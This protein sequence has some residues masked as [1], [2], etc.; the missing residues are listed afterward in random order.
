MRKFFLLSK[1]LFKNS[2]SI[3]SKKQLLP[4]LVLAICFLPTII[5]SVALLS[6][7]YELVTPAGMQSTILTMG[8]FAA[9]LLT[10]IF[11]IF[12]VPSLLYFSKDNEGLL[13]LPLTPIQVGLA[14]LTLVLPTS[15]I[16]YL[17]LAGPTVGV[18]LYQ[19]TPSLATS[20]LLICF[21]LLMPL[22][23]IALAG[24]I[25]TLFMRLVPFFKNK[26]LMN[27]IMMFLIL[28]VALGINYFFSSNIFIEEG[29]ILDL[30]LNDLPRYNQ[31]LTLILPYVSILSEG[32]LALNFVT[33]ILGLLI[34][35]GFIG[36]LVVFLN[37]FLLDTMTSVNVSH[38]K[39]RRLTNKE[40]SSSSG[41]SS[42]FIALVKKEVKTLL[43][44]PIFFQNCVLINY[45]F[46]ILLVFPLFLEGGSIEAI[47]SMAAVYLQDASVFFFLNIGFVLGFFVSNTNM[48]SA[49]GFSRMGEKFYLVRMLPVAYETQVH[50]LIW[51]GIFY[52]ATSFILIFPL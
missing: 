33:I 13:Y 18:Y 15:Y 51:T 35:V 43:R 32:A 26:D 12:F 7:G 49:T 10:F 45:L 22:G 37:L 44:T 36:V 30:L 42:S 48:I 50:A 11:A 23:A 3:K 21:S 4:Y 17:M 46:P 16:A 47:Q 27:N 28:A 38:S 6:Y 31:M 2:F 14:K 41:K 8:L 34:L 39:K 40:L 24:V 25:S 52:G 1:I 19:F 20:V 29:K 9:N 5:S